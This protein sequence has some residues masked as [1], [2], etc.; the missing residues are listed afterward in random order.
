[1]RCNLKLL[2]LLA[3]QLISPSLTLGVLVYS[4]SVSGNWMWS[5]G[6]RSEAKKSVNTSGKIVIVMCVRCGKC[7]IR[8]VRIARTQYNI[9]STIHLPAVCLLKCVKNDFWFSLEIKINDRKKYC[10]LSLALFATTGQHQRSVGRWK[11]ETRGRWW[12]RGNDE[13]SPF[14]RLSRQNK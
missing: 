13:F 2:L 8:L 6:S 10:P 7:T 4:I 12:R 14:K 11:W 3:D 1:M 9:M 5:S